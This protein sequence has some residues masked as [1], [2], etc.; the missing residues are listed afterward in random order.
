MNYRY[1]F[2][3]LAALLAVAPRLQAQEQTFLFSTNPDDVVEIGKLQGSPNVSV[4]PNAARELN[5]FVR[6]GADDPH[7]MRVQL[8]DAKGKVVTE[9]A[10]KAAKKSYTKVKFAK[11]MAPMPVPGAPPAPAAPPKPIPMGPPAPPGTE[12]E[13]TG[14]DAAPRFEFKLR[15]HDDTA[16]DTEW[17]KAKATKKDTLRDEVAAKLVK[18]DPAIV[19]ILDPGTYVKVIGKPQYKNAAGQNLLEIT[20]ESDAGFLTGSPCLI[21]MVFPP[22]PNLDVAAL[23]AGVYRKTI[24]EP[25]Q[26]VKLYATSLPLR[27]VDEKTNETVYLNVDGVPRVYTYR[28][29]L[30]NQRKDLTDIQEPVD[31]AIRLIEDGKKEPPAAFISMPKDRFPLRVEVDA[32]L[33]RFDVKLTQAN[34]EVVTALSRPGARH[35]RVWLEPAGEGGAFR[36]E[37]RVSDWVVPLDT[38]DMRGTFKL[39]ATL[40]G[41]TSKSFTRDL[42]LDD[43]PPPADKIMIEGI[44]EK[45]FRGRPMKLSILASDPESPITKVVVFLGKPAPDGKLPDPPLLIQATPPEGK[46]MGWVVQVPIPADK[47]GG[48]DDVTV[49]A[50]NAVNLST[51]KTITI[52]L[53]DPPTGG[54]IKGVVKLGEFGKG[55]EGANVILKDADGKAKDAAT[56]DKKGEYTFTDVPPGPYLVVAAKTDSGFGT[57][58]QTAVRVKAE[59]K[60]AIAD[61]VLT[62]KP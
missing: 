38:R 7:Q 34:G 26:K 43:T 39:T 50:T 51:A 60:P 13:V 20:V 52:Q 30:R 22:Q 56:T 46:G 4:R 45:Q 6:N 2:P 53:L 59:E 48:K 24:T 21:E 16:I 58:G 17:E 3:V 9:A 54:T 1:L 31:A 44:P 23:G 55:V 37:A 41:E 36:V 19:S 47:K 61:V 5:L 8:L 27:T 35:E 18:T 10:V 29:N 42:I 40:T 33:S 11:P 12:I 15:L 25:S 62:R 14:T 28:P 57:K 32:S 49:V